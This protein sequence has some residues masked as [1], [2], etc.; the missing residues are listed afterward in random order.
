MKKRYVVTAVIILMIASFSLMLVVGLDT[1]EPP[2]AKMF[3]MLEQ[4]E[5]T[6]EMSMSAIEYFIVRSGGFLW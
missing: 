5:M 6:S 2:P 1:S 3:S 4:P